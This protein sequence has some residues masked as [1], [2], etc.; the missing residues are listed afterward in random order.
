MKLFVGLYHGSE[1]LGDVQT[2]NELPVSGGNCDV[3]EKLT[4]DLPVMDVQLASR[5][6]FTL[7]GR[8]KGSKVNYCIYS[9]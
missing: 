6:C 9:V 3:N 7:H 4:F 5:L 8:M 1:V 2:T